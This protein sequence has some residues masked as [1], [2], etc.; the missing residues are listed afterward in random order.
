MRLVGKRLENGSQMICLSVGAFLW[1]YSSACYPDHG[2]PKSQK[3]ERADPST[4]PKTTPRRKFLRIMA[5][6][7]RKAGTPTKDGKMTLGPRKRI[8]KTAIWVDL[9][10]SHNKEDDVGLIGIPRFSEYGYSKAI[11]GA[12]QF[13]YDLCEDTPSNLFEK[14]SKNWRSAWQGIHS[15]RV[16]V[17]KPRNL[18]YDVCRATRLMASHESITPIIDNLNTSKGC[19]Y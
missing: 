10:Q 15:P 12:V 16:G 14:S 7:K 1:D 8:V 4:A 19:P 5:T 2:R 11:Q 6:A 9:I 18:K 13:Q 3:E 17:T